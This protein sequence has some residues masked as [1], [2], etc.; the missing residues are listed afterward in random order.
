[1]PLTGIPPAVFERK[2][3]RSHFPQPCG[4]KPS[5]TTYV[6]GSNGDRQC[7]FF[8][9]RLTSYVISFVAFLLRHL[10]A[11]PVFWPRTKMMFGLA[12]VPSPWR[13]QAWILVFADRKK[14]KHFTDSSPETLSTSSNCTCHTE[15]WS[16]LS[17]DGG[18]RGLVRLI[19]DATMKVLPPQQMRW[20]NLKSSS[21][22]GHFSW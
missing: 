6:S 2:Q 3:M 9:S 16:S 22:A 17:R 8:F 5:D 18:C 13:Q 10:L 11:T 14:R 20:W 12:V 7:S 19:L 21:P 4:Y 15:R 1:M